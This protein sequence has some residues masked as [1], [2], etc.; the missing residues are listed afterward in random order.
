EYPLHGQATRQYVAAA[1][2]AGVRVLRERQS[3][4]RSPAMDS[5]PRTAYWR[6]LQASDTDVQWIRGTGCRVVCRDGPPPEL[7]VQHAEIQSLVDRQTGRF[8][9]LFGT[10]DLADLSR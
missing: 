1:S 5:G 9:C 10:H 7:L 2:R 6:V 4:C 3:K 8:S